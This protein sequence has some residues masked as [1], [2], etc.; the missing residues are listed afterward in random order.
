MSIENKMNGA[1]FPAV[2]NVPRRDVLVGLLS[3]LVAMSMPSGVMAG[4][5]SNLIGA[6]IIRF[7]KFFANRDV[8]TMKISDAFAI[9]EKTI[10]ELPRLQKLHRHA[11]HAMRRRAMAISHGELYPLE[12]IS[13][14][15]SSMDWGGNCTLI[16]KAIDGSGVHILTNAHVWAHAAGSSAERFVAGR[17]NANGDDVVVSYVPIGRIHATADRIRKMIHPIPPGIRDDNLYGE[18][19]SVF[20]IDFGDGYENP[21]GTKVFSS[22]AVPVTGE[23]LDYK[24]EQLHAEGSHGLARKIAKGG[25]FMMATPKELGPYRAFAGMSGS[26]VYGYLKDGSIVQVGIVYSAGELEINGKMHTFVY[27]MGPSRIY[28]KI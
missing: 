1:K 19:V 18:P 7:R 4:F 8:S 6:D 26:P 23:L 17:E 12:N 13:P 9:I 28:G 22:I 5:V 3:S 14:L 27:F 25:V 2:Q 15:R 24:I 20:G 10:G 11:I 16:G 21:D